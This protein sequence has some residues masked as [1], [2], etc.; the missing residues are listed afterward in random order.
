[1][2][3]TKLAI[4]HLFDQGWETVDTQFVRETARLIKKW[5]GYLGEGP[6]ENPFA[7]IPT[8]MRATLAHMFENAAF[9]AY[10]GKLLEQTTTTDLAF[11]VRISLPIIR[12]VFAA[13]IMN[14]IASVRPMPLAS[15]GVVN[16]F[17]QNILREDAGNSNVTT[18]D[19]D[20]AY[21]VENA[22]PKRLKM[23]IT[24]TTIVATKDI[25]M[26]VWST[27]AQEDLL[28]GHGLSLEREMV[29]AMAQEILRELEERV[30]Q[31]MYVLA[32]AGTANWNWTQ[33]A[34]STTSATDY[35]QTI[36]H[37]M[38]DIDQLIY[39]NIFRHGDYLVCGSNVSAFIDK[40]KFY[41]STPSG[42]ESPSDMQ[43]GVEFRG[44]INN[45]WDVFQTPYLGANESLMGVYPISMINTGYI[46]APYIPM[47]AMPK[48]YAE[49]LA[50]DDATLPGAYINTDKWTRNVRTRNGKR[51]VQ[52]N[53]FA[54]M[55]IS[56]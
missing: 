49:A 9:L 17:Y 26:A 11:P 50:Y 1:M 56:A 25:L 29:A 24:Q 42:N 13:L 2:D 36:F 15:A 18:A 6:K 47:M 39:N 45:R 41:Q 48:I 20:Y 53:R 19:S 37:T 40:A 46:W 16:V 7:P 54:T 27:E 14:R 38:I 22:V 44:R 21:N 12:A 33:P 3:P 5:E 34:A 51:M 10:R 43:S 23:Q 4:E 30:I 31:E 52:P 8:E 28:G 32:T 55:T 35:Y